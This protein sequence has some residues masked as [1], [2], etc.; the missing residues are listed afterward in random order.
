MYSHFQPNRLGK[1][2]FSVLVTL[3]LAGISCAASDKEW[4]EVR[5]QHFRVIT[6][7]SESA[8]RRVARE[9]EQIRFAMSSVYPKL[10]MDPGAPLLV[11]CPRDESSMKALAPQFWKS[12]GF[13]PA[14]FFQHGWDKEYAVVR[15]DE[16]RPESYE[17]VYHE[18]VHSVMHLNLRW[19]PVWL[20][21]GLAEFHANTRFEKTKIFVGAPSWRVGVVRSRAAIPLNTLLSVTPDSP[22]YHDESKA[23]MFYAQSW[24]LTHYLFF[25][26]GMESGRKLLRFIN[27]LDDTE[28]MK[29]FEQVFGDLKAV[30]KGLDVY[31]MNVAMAGGYLNT[32]ATTDEKEFKSRRMSAAETEAELGS[33]HLWSH[34]LALARPFI[35]QAL[36]DDPN[37]GLAHEDMGFLDFAEGKDADAVREFAQA[38]ALDPKLY[39][40]LFSQTMMSPVAR[41]DAPADQAEFERA[42]E[43]VLDQNGQFAP[44]LVQLARLYVRQ[45]NLERAYAVARRAE[46]LEPARAGYHLLSGRILQLMGHSADA[47]AFARYVAARWQGPDHDEALELWNSIPA[48]QRPA[49]EALLPSVVAGTQEVEGVVKSVHCGRRTENE[50]QKFTLV[51]DQGGHELTFQPNGGFGTGYSDTLWWGRDHFSA[52]LHLQGIRT[53]VHYKPS[54]DPKYAGELARF[55]LRDDLPLVPPKPKGAENTPPDKKPAGSQ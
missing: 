22:Y 51:I 55:D 26:P 18:Y 41:L 44:A 45:G 1:L 19:I 8:A 35:E 11:I 2:I 23:D 4:A 20:D 46:Q 47:A 32:P 21:E 40:S 50:E 16:I 12:K 13:K 53:V 28:Q 34:D 37:L 15:L 33:Y 54:S 10:R 3:V 31:S 17:V 52:C 24:L 39:L 38:S 49:G 27:L 5:S 43:K 9:F 42:V 25:G 14:G 48:A 7:G 29:A 36:K 30:E 6:D